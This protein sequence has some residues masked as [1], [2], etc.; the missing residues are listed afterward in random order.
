MASFRTVEIPG[1]KIRPPSQRW[2]IYCQ[3][4]QIESCFE[5]VRIMYPTCVRIPEAVSNLS[6]QIEQDLLPTLHLSQPT[7][8]RWFAE[9]S[10][11]PSTSEF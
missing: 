4:I 3:A 2:G 5:L 7:P 9:S 8:I 10:L 6:R 11:G 1:F